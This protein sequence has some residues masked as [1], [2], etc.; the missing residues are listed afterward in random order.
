MKKRFT[1]FTAIFLLSFAYAQIEQNPVAGG[2]EVHNRQIVKPD[3]TGFDFYDVIKTGYFNMSRVLD[4]DSLNMTF[5]GNWPHGQSFSIASGG[6][7]DIFLVGS[8][9]ALLIVDAADPSNPEILSTVR[10]RA[11]VDASY[12]DPVTSRLY[13][14]AYFSGVEIWDL[15]DYAA[16][17]YLARIPT[18]SYPRGGV[19]AQGNYVY[20]VTVADGVYIFNTSDL[21]N[22]TQEGHYPISSSNLVWNSAKAGDFIYCACSNGGCRIV[23][24]SN[25][26]DPQ[27]AGLVGGATYAVAVELDRLFTLSGATGLRIYDVSDPASPVLSG[28]LAIEGNPNRVV[29]GGNYAYIANSTTNPGGGV[30]AVDVTDPENPLLSGIFNGFASYIALSGETVAFTGGG[31]GCTFLDV[32]DPAAPQQIHHIKLPSSVNEMFVLGDYAYTGS[33]GFRVFDVSDKMTPTEIGYHETPGALV[34]SD[35]QNAVYIPKSM[36]SSNPVNIMDVSDPA[37]PVKRGHYTAPVMTYD[38][39]LL[40]HYAFIACWWDGFRV[41]DFSDPDN[42]SLAAHEF[43]WVNNNSIP[44]EEYCFVQALDVEGNYLYLIDY[45]P[46]EDEDTKGLYVFDITDPVQPV[47]VSR[48]P[49]LI[50]QGYDVE[51]QGNYAYVSDKNGG[52]EVIDVSDPANPA[53]TGYV[54]LPDVGY[55]VDVDGS[56]AYVANYI[57]GG[58]QAVDVSNPASPEIAGYYTR[59]GCFA[60]GATIEG[61]YVYLADGPAGFQIYDNLIITRVNEKP[62]I[63]ENSFM[64]YPNPARDM[65][66]IILESEK[67]D[68]CRVKLMDITG[69]VIIQLTEKIGSGGSQTLQ[70]SLKEHGVPAGI[71]FVNLN[72]NGENQFRKLIVN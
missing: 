17:Q 29:V 53:T 70:I 46:F 2:L 69:K 68:L 51:V 66:N 23:D 39:D 64:L 67:P 14:A 1:F 56:F 38:I 48:Y 60:L 52:M 7:D 44:G 57:L 10:A 62:V 13:L 25:P 26:A 4:Y 19:F 31:L 9:G 37:N 55:S 45:G 3:L 47:F 8:G 27:L 40:G 41:V 61:S 72:M 59:S 71:Y 50:S 32:S 20:A 28:Q 5:I 34:A 43:G 36:T 54:Y 6:V 18:N 15:S 11:L 58:V 35:G 33:N 16:P 21:N 42:P 30:Q 49:G 65:I 22:I 12:F 63:S 24:V